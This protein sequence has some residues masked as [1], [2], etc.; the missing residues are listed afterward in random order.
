VPPPKF[1]VVSPGVAFQVPVQVVPGLAGF[2]TFSPAGKLSLKL[3][4]VNVVDALGFVS[5]RVIVLTPF[6]GMVVG[7]NALVTVG[8]DATVIEALP[9]FPVPAFVDVTLPVVLFFTPP[10]VPVMLTA[11]V[12][13]PLAA[14]VP[15]LK[16]S[17]VSPALGANVPPHE[18]DAPGVAATCR[19]D[20][21]ESVN[22]TPNN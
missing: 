21:S 20:G 19:P 10:V 9:V 8:G 12:Q 6:S 14:I 3:T 13:V 22:P 11:T 7:L 15:P 16:F 18:V 1:S 5:V 2:A 17:V 4:P